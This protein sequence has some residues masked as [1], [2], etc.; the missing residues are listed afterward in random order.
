MLT[1]NDLLKAVQNLHS[2]TQQKFVET[3][4]TSAPDFGEY[5]SALNY[6]SRVSDH[7]LHSLIKQAIVLRKHS[8]DHYSKIIQIGYH[9][10]GQLQLHVRERPSDTFEVSTGFAYG[11]NG[12]MRGFRQF[13]SKE[14]AL[15]FIED[16]AINILSD[17]N[18]FSS[19]NDL[20]VELW[21]HEFFIKMN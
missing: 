11:E 4:L 6:M 17:L 9:E 7:Q 12:Y 14:K 21:K 2:K 1:G 16:F 15:E 18:F 3:A 13:G 10:Y 8:D 20:A 5:R 19:L